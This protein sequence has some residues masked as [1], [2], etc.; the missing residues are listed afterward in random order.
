MN[1]KLKKIIF[2]SIKNVADKQIENT[3]DG[4]CLFLC[5]Q[6]KIPQNIKKSKNTIQ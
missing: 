1:N 4:K 6:P 5:Y 3:I 2:K